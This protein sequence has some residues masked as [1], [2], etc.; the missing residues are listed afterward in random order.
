MDTSSA[1][2]GVASGLEKEEKPVVEVSEAV[3]SAETR[4]HTT[5]SIFLNELNCGQAG[6]RQAAGLLVRR[7][8]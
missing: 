1:L 3:I 8:D 2:S 6:V 4:L 7:R 5:P